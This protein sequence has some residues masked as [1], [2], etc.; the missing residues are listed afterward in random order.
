MTAT[1]AGAG[2]LAAGLLVYAG[3]YEG[4][5]AASGKRRSLGTGILAALGG[6]AV[7]QLLLKTELVPNFRRT[8]GDRGTVA[9]YAALGI[10]A[11]R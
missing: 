8:L 6:F 1:L 5:L 7:D 10:A 9:K 3:L 4:T 11:A 2:V